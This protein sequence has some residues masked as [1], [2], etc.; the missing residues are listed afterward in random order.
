MAITHTKVSL[1]ADD[2]DTT[3]VRPSDWNASHA[4]A[5][6]SFTI[7][8]TTGLQTAL[9]AKEAAGTAAAA[10]V[11]HEAALDPHP[12]Y[13]TPAEGAAA[14]DAIG[15]AAAAQAAS[16]PL[17][18]QL[19][20]LAALSYSGNGSKVVRVN[21]GATDFELVTPTSTPGGSDTQVQFNDSSAFGGDATFTYN[22]TT[23]ILRVK[24]WQIWDGT[25]DFFAARSTNKYNLF[26]GFE[27]GKNSA[28]PAASVG[29]VDTG[30]AN[31]AVGY[32]SQLSATT[33]S[34]YNTSIGTHGLNGV[35]DGNSNTGLGANAGFSITTG[36]FNTY[37]GHD[38]G[39][40]CAADQQ[41]ATFVGYRSGYTCTGSFNVGVGYQ[42]LYV[43]TGAQNAALGYNAGSAI[44]SGQ[45]N[46]CMGASAGVSPDTKPSLVTGSG[47]VLIGV[48]ATPSATSAAG[49]FVVGSQ[50]T[51]ITQVYFGTGAT[52]AS[53]AAV[54][55]QSTT[56]IGTDIAGVDFT[57]AGGKGTGTGLGGAVRLK[58]SPA[59]S[60]GTT[61]GTLQDVLVASTAGIVAGAATGGA[62]GVG[63]INAVNLYVNGTAV[64]AGAKTIAM[65]CSDETTAITTGTAKVTFRMP[66]AMT[67]TAVRA[68]V[69]TAPTG[70]TIIIDIK[71]SGT[72]IL[73]TKLSIDAGA[74]TSTTA[75]SQAVISDTALADDAE[76][77]VNFDQVGSSVAGA[78]VKI[79]LIG[80]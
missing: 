64:G 12:G 55:V 14:Y 28:T 47:N 56:P 58:A 30:T 73:S 40:L 37:V 4:V 51:P 50:Y 68:S 24:S 76:I 29:G 18:A 6:S 9:D 44:T 66:Y 61:A 17:D 65:A 67:L 39:K 80:S 5:D 20:S 46:V 3:L 34:W 27:A 70:S 49:E 13:L 15:A 26:I 75:A 31:T 22:K 21:A 53:P 52:Y 63:T 71:E 59:G 25:N 11:T 72:T 45:Y 38:S 69:G 48:Y 7:A 10:I 62:K 23:D 16:Q 2:P 77:T 60:T 33:A 42:A 74:K 54:T 19:T 36:D 78:G 8:K 35:T 41:N 1:V 57:I 79:Y 32:Q 43:T